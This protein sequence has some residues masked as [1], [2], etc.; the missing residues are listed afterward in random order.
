MLRH[1]CI[2]RKVDIGPM[3]TLLLLAN[4]SLLEGSGKYCM[5]AMTDREG[6]R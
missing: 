2:F 3:L 4:H 6:R 5:L 1:E